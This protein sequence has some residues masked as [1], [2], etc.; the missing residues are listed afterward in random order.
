MA[1]PKKNQFWKKRSKHG[2]KL[3]FESPELLWKAA[4]EYFSWVDRNPWYRSEAIKSGNR[5]GDIIQV[6][7]ARPYTLSGFCLYVHA[8]ES[9]WRDF[10]SNE[11]I[12]E[13]FS[14]VISRIE[15]I[16]RTQKFEGAT[17][18]VFNANIIAQDLG[19]RSKIDLDNKINFENLPEEK[20]DEYFK[21]M[22]ENAAKTE[23]N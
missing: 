2:R 15:D 11:N 16:I 7:T 4:Q 20:L 17:V 9:F 13:G 8:S 12:Q 23:K 21:L 6:P 1:A 10:R 18:G 14:S 5:T 19:L 3:L 22:I